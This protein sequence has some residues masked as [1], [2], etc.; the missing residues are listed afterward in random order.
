[1]TFSYFIYLT[2]LGLCILLVFM[3]EIKFEVGNS[4]QKKMGWRKLFYHGKQ[5]GP[6]TAQASRLLKG[7]YRI[8][9]N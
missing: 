5:F 7:W 4:I 3:G 8:E 6:M 2:W 1:M 9:N